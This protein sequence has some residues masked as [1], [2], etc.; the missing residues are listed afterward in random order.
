[1]LWLALVAVP[2]VA[3]AFRPGVSASRR[4]LATALV[5]LVPLAGPLLAMLVR[6]IRGGKVALEPQREEP[7]RR[8]APADVNRLAELPPVLE[9]L[10]AEDPAERLAALV[11][12][13]SVGDL[14]AM[15]VLRWTIEHGPSEVV[16]EAALTLEEIDLR[17]EAQAAARRARVTVEDDGHRGPRSDERGGDRVARLREVAALAACEVG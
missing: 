14:A 12:L 9:R 4:A 13:S 8:P 1:M 15:A 16:L 5:V 6:R 7:R 3:L 2:W 17:G 10:L 11:H